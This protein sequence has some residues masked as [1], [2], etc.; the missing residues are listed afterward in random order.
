MVDIMQ[1]VGHNVA[2]SQKEPHKAHSL[3]PQPLREDIVTVDD[4]LRS[5]V[6][7][8]PDAP[9]VG[10]PR[11]EA[12]KQVYVFYSPKELDN[13]TNNFVSI[14]LA[15]G[16]TASE[17]DDEKVVA[18]LAPSD[19]NYVITLFALIRMRCTVLLL[20]TRLSTEAYIDLLQKTNC[21]HILG[22]K[23]TSKAVDSIRQ[24]LSIC[25]LQVPTILEDDSESTPV[26]FAVDRKIDP[27]RRAFIIHSSGSTGLPK[28]I[29]Q[30]HS[31]CIANYSNGNGLR[32][33]LTLPL[34]HN[35]GL[36]TFFR[37]VYTGTPVALFNAQLPLSAT[38]LV[39]ALEIVKPTSFH[40][41]PYALKLLSESERGIELL[42]QCKLVL[43][44]GSSCPDELGD[45][46]VRAGVY[47]VSHYGATEMGQLMTSFRTPEDKAWNYV[48]PSTEVAPYLH[49]AP[50][51]ENTF[52]CVV[53]DGWRSKVTSNSDDPPNSFHTSDL[54]QPHPDIPNAWRYV[55]RSDDR[56]T[57]FNGEKVLPIPIEHQIRQNVFVKE[58]LVFGNGKAL[59]GLL[60][61]PSERGT[62]LSK[63]EFIKQIWPSIVLANKRSE[64]FSQI[65]E[66]MIEVLDT[67][68]DYPATD[69]GTI[70]RAA[71]YK[72]FSSLID[73]VYKR[74]ENGA[75]S[76]PSAKLTLSV[77]EL[78][79]FLLQKIE[80]RSNLKSLAATTDFFDAGVDSLQ[81]IT[82]WAYLNKSLDVGKAQLGQNVLFEYPTVER[83]A[84]HLYGLRI[85]MTTKQ[86]DET[87]IMQELITKY[88]Q[89]ERS[90]SKSSEVILLTD[91]VT[92]VYCLVRA[93]SE[94]AA[95]DRV[96]STLHAKRLMPFANL[97]KV[98]AL[99]SD[100]GRSDLGLSSVALSEIRR[101]LTKVI[102]SAWAV[103][104][105][106]GIRSFEQQHIKGVYN[107]LNLCLSVSGIH[108]AQ[109][110]FCSSISA[111]A[112][113]PLPA[114]IDE[115]PVEH[116][117]YA[118]SIGY[119][120][121]KLVAEKI[122]QKAAESKNMVAKVLRVGQIVGDSE[123]G[124]WNTTEAICLMIQ[125]AATMGVLPALDETPSWLP[126]DVVAEVILDLSSINISNDGDHTGLCDPLVV[127]QVQ[128]PRLFHWTDDLLPALRQAGLQFKTIPQREW[129]QCLRGSDPDPVKNPTRKLLSFFEDKY[130]NE[131]LGRQGLKFKTEKTE[132]ASKT[133]R[134][135]MDIVGT[136]LIDK[137]VKQW[138][139]SWRV[140]LS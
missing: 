101:A 125:S 91:H 56:I 97:N 109:F 32:A 95:T 100:L 55:A 46:L 123:H 98:V 14:L 30:S 4:L 107:L 111:A 57:L 36:S 140:L 8:I 69:K 24:E 126:V 1:P 103:N 68:T 83:L 23:V 90:S 106:L 17:G 21:R 44:G 22:S 61:V 2:S 128:N 3:I 119:A 19:I 79:S 38:N 10:Y 41:V 5:R 29:F 66:E 63:E 58:A 122:V 134:G 113:T 50:R 71:S 11:V 85:G 26:P 43:F 45:S 131:N 120:R 116:L 84:Q 64:G 132:N 102:H 139:A 52:E 129:I 49:F 35:H 70:I 39:E 6:A 47:L 34:F 92:R 115:A 59:P 118:Q 48:R 33:F 62:K 105:N 67:N 18:V 13:L 25:A 99:P 53:L 82:I 137:I 136:D 76:G 65:S 138:R 72:R 89:F 121:S 37:A 110:Y 20:S 16:L 60:V 54:F 75:G 28:P 78:E 42:R 130:D 117:T 7:T 27:Q 93:S 81:A 74:F 135:G 104:F 51:A 124:I 12:G 127:Y 94:S 114:T 80:A 96:L 40:G 112:G 77:S 31:A 87:G 86:E 73:A 15:R 9:I 108:P 133:M 88:T